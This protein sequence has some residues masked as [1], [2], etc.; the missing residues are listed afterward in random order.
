MKSNQ[1]EVRSLIALNVKKVWEY[2]TKPEH[3]VRWNF[4]ADDW[5]CPQA[6]NDLRVG[7]KY[8]ARMEAKDG[9]FGF[10]FTAVYD[11]VSTGQSLTYTMEDGRR[12]TADFREQEG[13]TLVTVKFDPEN[14]NPVEMQRG[15]WQAILDNFKKY[16]EAH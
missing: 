5:H 1:I 15:G 14:E 2:Y 9:S 7:G 11:A 6:E 13:G 10:D 3:I 16:A 8:R 4:A 12:A